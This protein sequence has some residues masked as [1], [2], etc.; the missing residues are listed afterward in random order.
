MRF[1]ILD[2]EHVTGL[3]TTALLSFVKM[4]QALAQHNTQLLFTAL[5]ADSAEQFAEQGLAVSQQYPTLDAALQYV[6]DLQL[7]HWQ[8]DN[9]EQHN[10]L[11]SNL[12]TL[13]PQ[14]D[15]ASVIVIMEQKV[16]TAGDYLMHQ[17]D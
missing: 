7:T 13:V 3:D 14:L 11:I 15:I 8:A 2:F 9:V 16:L 1:V 5:D 4:E 12:Y 6:E 10:T 17:G